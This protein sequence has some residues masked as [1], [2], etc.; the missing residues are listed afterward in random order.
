[1]RRRSRET[2]MSNLDD[3]RASRIRTWPI[4]LLRVYAG[5]YFLYFG[6]RK[7]SRGN[8]A[9]GL[10][11]SVSSRL[12][13]SFWMF[14][15]FLEHVVLPNPGVFAV[16]VSWGEVLIGLSLI[17]GLATRYSSIAGAFMVLCFWMMKGQSILNGQNHDAIWFV[18]FIV[19]AGLHA[20][21]TMGLDHKLSRRYRF[22]A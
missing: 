4:L 14:R 13:D 12:E 9:D 15:P 21:R 1:M 3:F 2:M 8:F 18:L 19:L 11:A 22:L 5:L 16:L 17:V 7:I 6:M 20:G 10:T